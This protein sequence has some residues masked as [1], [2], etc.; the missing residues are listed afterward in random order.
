M[1]G[2]SLS[3]QAGAGP[4]PPPGPAASGDE[5]NTPKQPRQFKPGALITGAA[6]LLTPPVAGLTTT[7][8]GASMPVVALVVVMSLIPAIP[9]MVCAYVWSRGAMKAIQ[10]AA[11]GDPKK[12]G[13]IISALSGALQALPPTLGGSAARSSS[14]DV[15][16]EGNG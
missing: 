12:S 14:P 6:G 13:D 2:R 15:G 8:L 7:V 10:A 1:P 3:A 4:P 11:R 16:R 9:M 5:A